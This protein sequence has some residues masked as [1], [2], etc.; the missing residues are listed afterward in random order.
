MIA[1]IHAAVESESKEILVAVLGAKGVDVDAPAIFY[2]TGTGQGMQFGAVD[3]ALISSTSQEATIT[4]LKL[5]PEKSPKPFVWCSG[6]EP[7]TLT[8][9]SISMSLISVVNR[10]DLDI[11]SFLHSKADLGE[12]FSPF[13]SILLSIKYNKEK[14]F[15]HV[16]PYAQ[17]VI[18]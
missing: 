15:T 13:Y 1:P 2:T 8:A 18:S 12:Q 9:L 3:L 5:L 6:S 14:V 4:T 10:Q 17:G 11:L 16:L 7:E